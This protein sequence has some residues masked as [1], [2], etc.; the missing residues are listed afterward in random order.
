MTTPPT[1]PRPRTACGG[2]IADDPARYPRALYRGQTVYF[3]L[4]ACR[5]VF[6]QDPGGFMAGDIPHPN[7][8]DRAEN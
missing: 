6:E 7:E 4:R 5:R 8:E 1:D 2:V 3:C